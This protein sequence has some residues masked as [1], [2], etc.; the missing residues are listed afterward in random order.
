MMIIVLLQ[1]KREN[2]CQPHPLGFYLVGAPCGSYYF[3]PLLESA[4]ALFKAEGTI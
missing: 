2:I 1:M 3:P 4:V